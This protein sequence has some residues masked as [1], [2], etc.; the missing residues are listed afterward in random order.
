MGFDWDA[1]FPY[2]VRRYIVPPTL[3]HWEGFQLAYRQPITI[4]RLRYM[5]D[6]EYTIEAPTWE[7]LLRGELP[8]RF[9]YRH[10]DIAKRNGGKRQIAEPG[11]DLK[12]LQHAIVEQ[13]LRSRPLHR[14]VTGY[15][16]GYSVADHVWP[17]VGARTIITADI[18]DFFPSTTRYRIRAFWRDYPL[19]FTDPEIQLLTNLTTYRGCLPQGA[20]T[21]PTLSNLVN[22][23]LDAR[24]TKLIR[25]SSGQYTRYADDM[26]FSWQTKSRPP[27]DFEPTV[28]RILRE[29]GYHLHAQKGWQV[30]SR[31]DEAHITGVVVKR[32]GTVDVPDDMLAKMRA[33]RTGDAADALVLAGYEG[34]LRMIRRR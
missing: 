31:H 11:V 10:F 27:T 24:L 1:I 29:Y 21:S 3:R 4:W 12:R 2:G 5:L 9:R 19:Q 17:H 16:R 6:P 23:P 20:P 15:R 30:W 7:Q 8:P 26:V 25:Q 22:H 13:M 28:R 18:R 32:N 34:Y 33:L 14:A